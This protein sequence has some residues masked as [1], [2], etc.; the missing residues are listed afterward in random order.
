ML[1]NGIKDDIDNLV[2]Y[3]IVVDSSLVLIDNILK[4]ISKTEKQKKIGMET[5]EKEPKVIYHRINA[6]SS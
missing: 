1:N 6:D 2:D 4:I 3:L 5:Y